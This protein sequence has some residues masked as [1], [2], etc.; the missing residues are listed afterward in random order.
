MTLGVTKLQLMKLNRTIKQF[1]EIT[2][3]LCACPGEN[4]PEIQMEDA[5]DFETVARKIS[6]GGAIIRKPVRF[7]ANTYDEIFFYRNSVKIYMVIP[8]DDADP[9]PLN[10]SAPPLRKMP[11]FVAAYINP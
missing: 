11:E 3:S 5:A 10:L 6:D 1:P 8:H 2:G 7:T 4:G 9:F